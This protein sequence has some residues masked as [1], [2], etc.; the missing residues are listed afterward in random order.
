MKKGTATM[1]TPRVLS[2]RPGNLE[3]GANCIQLSYTLEAKQ[4]L[5]GHQDAIFKN[6]FI[7]LLGHQKVTVSI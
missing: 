6:C 5:P 3:P 4:I 2:A 1:S 7:Y